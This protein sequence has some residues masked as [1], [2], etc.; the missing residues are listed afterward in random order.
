M[1]EFVGEEQGNKVRKS[2]ENIATYENFEKIGAG[3]AASEAFS[4]FQ[5]NLYN[6]QTK[7]LEKNPSGAGLYDLT[8]NSINDMGASIMASF[9]TPEMRKDLQTHL[10][11]TAVVELSKALDCETQMRTAHLEN[12]LD[13][14]VRIASAKISGGDD[15]ELSI[16]I[17]DSAIKDLP[18]KLKNKYELDF[19]KALAYQSMTKLCYSAPETAKANIDRADKYL[20]DKE[21]LLYCRLSPQQ[22]AQFR[23]VIYGRQ[24]DLAREAI[25]MRGENIGSAISHPNASNDRFFQGV[26]SGDINYYE[27][28]ILKG[29]GKISPAVY[30]GLIRE[31]DQRNLREIK[32]KAY[33]NAS[34]E[35]ARAAGNYGAVKSDVQQRIFTEDWTSQKAYDQSGQPIF[36]EQAAVDEAGEPILDSDGNQKVERRPLVLGEC[37]LPYIADYC[38]PFTA[39][40]PIL[41]DRIMNDMM[42]SLDPAK[43]N[44]A[45]ETYR[46]LKHDHAAVLGNT[47]SRFNKEMTE[48]V[49][50]LDRGGGVL[51]ARQQ[52]VNMRGNLESAK[53]REL[54]YLLNNSKDDRFDPDKIKGTRFDKTDP[55]ERQAAKIMYEDEFISSKGNSELAYQVA[56]TNFESLKKDSGINGTAVES[57]GIG[58]PES[59]IGRDARESLTDYMSEKVADIIDS[60]EGREING[61]KNIEFPEN[62]KTEYND[63]KINGKDAYI[64]LVPR[65]G[66]GEYYVKYNYME[67]WAKRGFGA[68]KARFNS[69]YAIT[70]PK[71]G[72]PLTIKLNDALNFRGEEKVDKVSLIMEKIANPPLEMAQDLQLAFGTNYPEEID[73]VMR[74]YGEKAVNA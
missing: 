28:E 35:T 62:F 22:R 37:P 25:K 33:I 1:A 36:G 54:R 44:D 39:E 32:D 73:R 46:R 31:I 67:G 41:Q 47:S 66:E 52:I 68:P 19:K 10:N 26:Q 72:E 74:F 53:E 29:E 3:I 27:A 23:Q 21:N 49:S 64:F 43:T 24:K 8:L 58:Y 14:L 13:D 11:H 45:I 50:V 18:E 20:K 60:V 59:L 71:T 16:S 7:H 12:D 48:A 2:Q 70:D 4:S 61:I 15:P 56:S 55:Y 40:L 34:R 17:L 51:L 63:V 65:N 57:S 42:N 69:G 6:K 30:K 9:G 5:I 38:K